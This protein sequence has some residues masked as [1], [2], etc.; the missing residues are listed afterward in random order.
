[1]RW[2]DNAIWGLHPDEQDTINWSEINEILEHKSAGIDSTPTLFIKGAGRIRFR[3]YFRVKR[4]E[5]RP[6]SNPFVQLADLFSGL[7]VF[8]R[9]NYSSYREW[10]RS[11][12]PQSS[13]FHRETERYSWSEEH[14]Y[15][16]LREFN[17]LAKKHKLGISFDTHKGLRTMDPK[18]PIN[19]WPYIPQTDLDKAPTTEPGF[20]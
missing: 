8:S 7:S 16:V 5:E 11:S 2:E 9:R 19:F 15:V 13:L 6:S 10:E 12:N 17:K 18:Y 4:I 3:R 20:L 1:M 14:R